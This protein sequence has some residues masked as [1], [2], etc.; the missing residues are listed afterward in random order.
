M[1]HN[2]IDLIKKTFLWYHPVKKENDNILDAKDDGTNGHEIVVAN[3]QCIDR[4]CV[5]DGMLTIRYLHPTDSGKY[6]CEAKSKYGKDQRQVHLT[7]KVI[8]IQLSILT[9]KTL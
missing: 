7:V 8:C 2:Y 3:G 6:I 4:V 9:F 5:K 1:H